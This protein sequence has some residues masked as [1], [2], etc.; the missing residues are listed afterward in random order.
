MSSSSSWICG[1][2]L[3]QIV[4]VLGVADAGDDVFALG[5]DEEVAVGPVLA[6]GGVAGE[7]DAG[8]RVVVAV[9]EHHR[10][11][12]DGRAQVVADPLAHPIGDRPG[13]V[14][15]LE[16]RLHG[17]AELLDRVLRERLAGRFLDH[18]LVLLAQLLQHAGRELGVVGDPGLGLG[19]LERML[20]RGAV[21]VEHDAPVHREEPAVRVVGE[22]LVGAGGEPL[23]A[24]VVET[25]V[26][27][28]VHHPGH[29]ELGAR[30]HAD[31]ERVARVAEPA[32]HLA[33]QPGDVFGDLVVEPVRP[34]AGHVRPAGV[35]GDGEARRHRQ[36]ATRWSSRRGWRP[37]HRADP[38][39]PSAGGDACDRRRRRTARASSLRERLTRI[40]G[41]Q[42]VPYHRRRMPPPV[43]RPLRVLGFPLHVRTGFLL[44][45]VLLVF[46]NGDEFGVWLAAAVAGFTLLHELGH[47]VAARRAGAR[48]EVSLDFMA[49]YTSYVAPRPLSL[50]TQ[51]LI[52]LA[53]PVTH[54]TAGLAVLAVMGVNP[55]DEDSWQRSAATQAVWW[56]GPAIGLF[57]LLPVLPLDGGNV[58]TNVLERFLPGRARRV[59]LYASLALT[60]G[61]AIWM[62]FVAQTRCVHRVP[63]AARG[64]AAAAGVRR[65]VAARR[66]TVRQ[67][68]RRAAGG[69]PRTRHADAGQRPAPAGRGQR[70]AA[71]PRRRR[72]PGAAGCAPPSAAVRRPVQRVRAG[73]P[74]PA[75]RRSSTRR[76][77]TG[78]SATG[79]NHAR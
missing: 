27:D 20:E 79:A 45:I 4:E 25:E 34:P 28:G 6:G 11:H 1:K 24:A 51:A 14:P 46:I 38:S 71:H 17:A 52:A 30:P 76:P 74:A 53:G 59:A 49:G 64:D 39:S 55:L 73:Q 29:R 22:A 75:H 54:I 43:H 69:R 19:V 60:I 67:G 41:A 62:A 35:G 7:A 33:L 21:D 78:P 16:H 57:N 48:A 26:Q 58:V 36:V 68:A 32:A 13:A 8:A 77:A 50:G 63:R 61:A 2:C 65:P 72:C 40:P 10:L 66:V 42:D 70:R 9:A 3:R 18:G 56:A 37:C 12:V 47:A 31:E 23:D 15:A 5:V 44:F